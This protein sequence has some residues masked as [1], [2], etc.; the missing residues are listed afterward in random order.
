MADSDDNNVKSVSARKQELLRKFCRQRRVE[1]SCAAAS[2]PTKSVK[3]N[4]EILQ[5][6]YGG[7]LTAHHMNDSNASSVNTTVTCQGGS[8]VD[9]TVKVKGD[10]LS[11]AKVS[12]THEAPRRRSEPKRSLGS[13]STKQVIVSSRM[14]SC[15]PR[16]CFVLKQ[17]PVS[18]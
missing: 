13:S 2:S 16:M 10:S 18:F 11:P 1:T 8:D 14:C 7:T 9:I 15:I 3:F 4:P 6:S 5:T 17:F 12:I